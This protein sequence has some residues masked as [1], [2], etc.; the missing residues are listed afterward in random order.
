[1]RGVDRIRPTLRRWPLIVVY[2]ITLTVVYSPRLAR[3]NVLKRTRIIVLCHV[4]R[5]GHSIGCGTGPVFGLTELGRRLDCT[6]RPLDQVHDPCVW[7]YMFDQKIEQVKL[8]LCSWWFGC[9]R[10]SVIHWL[11]MFSH[12]SPNHHSRRHS[13][14]GSIFW[15]W[16]EVQDRTEGFIDCAHFHFKFRFTPPMMSWWNVDTHTHTHTHTDEGIPGVGDVESWFVSDWR[17]TLQQRCCRTESWILLRLY[18]RSPCVVSSV[19]E[20]STLMTSVQASE[21][22]EGYKMNAHVLNRGTI[23]L[24]YFWMSMWSKTKN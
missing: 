16:E 21:D 14:T 6:R 10:Q 23:L 24:S 15:R 11:W 13:F 3:H 1:M 19:S 7:E 5:W 2:T 18:F 12:S 22:G 9:V 17:E 20:T 8:S 4:S